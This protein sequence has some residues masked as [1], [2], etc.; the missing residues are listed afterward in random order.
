MMSILDVT[1][2]RGAVIGPDLVGVHVGHAAPTLRLTLNGSPALAPTREPL[3][4]PDASPSEARLWL[5]VATSLADLVVVAFALSSAGTLLHG[6][7]CEWSGSLF[8]RGDARRNDRITA[9]TRAIAHAL[10]TYAAPEA[11]V[12]VA[13]TM[14][15]RPGGVRML[16]MAD[17][18]ALTLSLPTVT[19]ARLRTPT[20]PIVD[21][22]LTPDGVQRVETG[23]PLS[24]DL[25]FPLT[26]TARNAGEAFGLLAAVSTFLAR[27]R[28]LELP[29]SA[30]ACAPL[31]RWDLDAH[32]FASEVAN[33]AHLFRAVIRV[34]EVSMPW[35]EPATRT[36]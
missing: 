2:V 32:S 24:V 36:S 3:T 1:A 5:P 11:R 31:V 8:D 12:A 16:S 6:S 19:V 21:Q 15:D 10:R 33:G 20:Q 35:T 4:G 13:T 22:H 17:T 27:T 18:P 14:E 25:S 29:D 9:I 34:R 28:W 23:A 26:G 30:R 7:R